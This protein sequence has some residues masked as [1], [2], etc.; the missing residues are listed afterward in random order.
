MTASRR[1]FMKSIRSRL[2]ANILAITIIPVV[3]FLVYSL[4]FVSDDQIQSNLKE[5]E[6]KIAWASQHLKSHTGQLRDVMYALHLEDT[7]LAEIHNPAGLSTTTENV[8]R[9]T[10]YA[11][12]NIVSSI[13][14]IATASNRMVSIDYERGFTRRFLPDN[15]VYAPLQGTPVGIGYATLDKHLVAYH[16]I[17]DFKTQQELGLIVLQLKPGFL[18]EFSDIFGADTDFMLFSSSGLITAN[19]A[20]SVEL[21]DAV[22]I[23]HSQRTSIEPMVH[24]NH[25]IWSGRVPSQDVYIA[26]MVD[27]ALITG[28]NNRMISIAGFIILLSLSI[29][30]PIA[31]LLSN[32]ITDPIT[33]LVS[34]MKQFEFSHV[35]GDTKRYDELKLLEES[36]N[37]MIDAMSKMVRER[38]ET[39]IA[40]QSAQLKALQAQINPHF[41]ANTF[42]MISGMALHAEAPDIYDA[43]L[44]MSQILRYSMKI[45]KEAVTLHDEIEHIADYLSIQKLRFGEALHFTINVP[46][47]VQRIRLPKL[48]LQPIIE[49]SFRHGFT[50]G[51]D[52][53]GIT[54]D[55]ALGES[56]M[57]RITDDGSGISPDRLDDINNTLQ[58]GTTRQT[59]LLEDDFPSIGLANLDA[60]IKLLY[61]AR[62]G[63]RLE[64]ASTGGITT[65]LHLPK[66]ALT[67]ATT[68]R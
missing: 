29:T 38:Y 1:M 48:T 44:K 19:R 25:Y 46:E 54:I 63:I 64:A 31:I 35:Q 12:S 37:Q 57:I 66:E 60:R 10:L 68:H 50:K 26:A 22:F 13:T 40:M 62:Y 28:L 56:L 15:H 36:Y 34:H 16:T 11:N 58:K 21:V 39:K 65:L 24:E 14:V 55:H 4:I 32:R 49:N 45:N 8:L 59:V 52:T 51:R 53:M 23:H 42:Q 18:Q 7:L 20:P 30:I 43:T 33:Q 41:L 61:G 67:N 6:T 9:N 47:T 5:N 3:A 2:I 27:A 17:N